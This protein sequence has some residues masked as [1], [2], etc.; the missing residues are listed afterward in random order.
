MDRKRIV[1]RY[2][3]LNDIVLNGEKVAVFAEYDDVYKNKYNPELFFIDAE[4]AE[5]PCRMLLKDRIADTKKDWLSVLMINLGILVLLLFPIVFVVATTFRLALISPE[6]HLVIGTI[7]A[8]VAVTVLTTTALC[9]GGGVIAKALLEWLFKMDNNELMKLARK[10]NKL[11]RLA[12]STETG[13]LAKKADEEVVEKKK[14][15]FGSRQKSKWSKREIAHVENRDY[16]LKRLAAIFDV[17]IEEGAE[18]GMRRIFDEQT[19][20]YVIF[21]G[22]LAVEEL[23]NFVK[24]SFRFKELP[25]EIAELKKLTEKNILWRRTVFSKDLSKRIVERE[26]ELETV[27]K[28]IVSFGDRFDQMWHEKKAAEVDAETLKVLAA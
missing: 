27:R 17:G 22:S 9:V 2:D 13:R 18:A 19:D 7:T 1:M 16:C 20:S 4:W 28:L 5:K 8:T 26:T 21:L 15:I 24:A 11:Q 10:H 12:I 14:F 25:D 3:K 6:K 23:Q